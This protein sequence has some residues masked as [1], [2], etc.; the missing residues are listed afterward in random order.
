MK[1]INYMLS[2]LAAVLAIASCNKMDSAPD[3]PKRLKTVEVSLENAALTKGLAGN[4]IEAG[5]AVIINNLKIFFTDETGNEYSAKVADGSENAKT[6]WNTVD[7][8]SGP[9]E[10]S[11]HY[12]DPNC[13]RVIAVANMGDDFTFA[14][15]KALENLKIENQQKQD[16]LVLYDV[17]DLVKATGTHTDEDTDGNKYVSDV[18]KAD[19]VLSPRI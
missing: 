10:A 11:F 2:A 13:T 12:V 16:A 19:I 14:Q 1:R 15:Y 6:F 9:I 3:A 5:D 7:L 17:K 18:Y 4:K 8:A